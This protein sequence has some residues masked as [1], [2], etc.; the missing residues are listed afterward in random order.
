MSF[1]NTGNPVPSIDPRDLDDN[2]KIL[3]EFANG[4]TDTYVDRL[5]VERRTLFSI[6]HDADAA[7][8]R[9]D[10]ANATNPAKGATLIGRGTVNIDLISDLE[11][12]P[13]VVGARAHVK[14]S[15]GG[16]SAANA[17]APAG[18]ATATFA[19]NL[20][21]MSSDVWVGDGNVVIS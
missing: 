4:T 7:L 9:S 1:Y 11:T 21:N 12:V 6:E 20:G 5:G 15:V 8:L 19:L 10:L 2:A 16:W 3:D 13:R 14:A 17:I 18:T